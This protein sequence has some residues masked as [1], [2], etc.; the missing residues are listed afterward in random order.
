M[1]DR[2]NQ[3]MRE[4]GITSRQFAEEIGIQPSSLSHI[5]TGRNRPSLD[6]V[7]KIMQRWPDIDINWLMFGKGDMLVD[8]SAPSAP[9]AV[10]APVAEPDLF[11]LFPP[12]PPAPSVPVSL[13]EPEP[14]PEPE[15]EPIPE[16]PQPEPV[17]IS[18]PS[19]P[20]PMPIPEPPQSPKEP[21]PEPQK[22][23]LDENR[24]YGSAPAPA[25]VQAAH[26]EK[27]LV[28]VI[29]LFSDHTCEEFVP[30]A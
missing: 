6:F 22:P 13:P 24:L 5:L 12:D 19:Q 14:V 27:R 16:P 1:I 10:A 15:P 8:P 11:T 7:M 9:V 2:I 30:G 23:Q 28:K 25:P 29:L 20:E 26:D 21:L 18:E 17:S 4:K 3:V